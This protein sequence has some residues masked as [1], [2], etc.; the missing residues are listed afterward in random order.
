M[1]LLLSPLDAYSRKKTMRSTAAQEKDERVVEAVAG[2]GMLLL[3]IAL[4]RIRDER[5]KPP[6]AE[7]IQGI[8]WPVLGFD[9][10]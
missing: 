6:C 7:Q 9:H 4:V 3:L 1:W 5:G 2:A 10:E 8:G